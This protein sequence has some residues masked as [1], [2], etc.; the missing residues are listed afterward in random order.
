MGRVDE[1]PEEDKS[2]NRSSISLPDAE[3]IADLPECVAI[4]EGRIFGMTECIESGTN[5]VAIESL[6][7]TK[8]DL[9]M[10]N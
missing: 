8:I 1:S 9:F 2:N 7:A 4:P 3:G 10:N 6:K 5:A